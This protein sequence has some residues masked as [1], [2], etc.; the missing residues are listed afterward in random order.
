MTLNMKHKVNDIVCFE[1]GSREGPWIE[2][3]KILGKDIEALQRL[4]HDGVIELELKGEQV[5]LSGVD[6]VGLIVL[7]SGRRLAI[8][9][10]IESL[11]LLDW[12]AFLGEF[13]PLEAWLADTGVTTGNDIHACIARL[14]LYELEKVTR[15]HIRKDYSTVVKNEPTIRGRILSTQLYRRL[16]NLP[17]IPQRSRS[18][19]F[20]TAYNIVLALALDKLPMLLTN[21]S[22]NDRMILGRLR[23]LWVHIQR[24]IDDPVT[25]VTEAQWASP[26]GYR[27]SLQLARLILIGAALDSKS[28][29]GG[30]A[31]TLSLS[32]IWERSLRRMFEDISESTGW[33]CA[34]NSFRTRQWND[35]VGRNDHARWLTADVI[36]NCEQARWVLDAKY[37]RAFG[38]ES[39][40]DRF[41]MYAYA[42]AFDAGR[43]SLVYPTASDS[44]YELRTLLNTPVGGKSVL[45]DSIDLPMASGPEVCM[46]VLRR[47][48]ESD[49]MTPVLRND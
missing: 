47:L 21:A 19:T 2:S 14:F 16:H 48:A 31:F 4:A 24:E 25:A 29:M 1:L 39:R 17:F 9:S 28:D 20:D 38:N 49:I 32:L 15:L 30:Q 5:Y 33:T 7:P 23:E 12:L 10:K 34:S 44:Q 45:I 11:V 37:K 36:L 6:R 3:A 26:P 27:S 41:Q 18:R 46:N 43:V 8:R 40:T 13:P 42:V 35:S 22:Q